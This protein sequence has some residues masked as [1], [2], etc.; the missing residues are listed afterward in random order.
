MP[1]PVRRDFLKVA[2]AGALAV[3]A[4]A[5]SARGAEATEA[6]ALPRDA[7]RHQILAH[8]EDARTGLV[9]VMV[10]GR[11]VEILDHDLVARLARAVSRKLG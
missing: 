7:H 3:G 11:E 4:V 8:V 1:S 5:V 2:G 9:T 6:P 10:E